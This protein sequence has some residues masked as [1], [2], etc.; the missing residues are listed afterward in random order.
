MIQ[1]H[2][3]STLIKPPIARKISKVDAI[4]GDIRTDDYFWLREK[5][6][7]DVIAYLDS[8]NA[9]TDAV[10]KPLENLQNKLYKETLDRIKQTDLSVPYKYG[11][12]WYY[13]RTEEGKQYQIY[14]R[15]LQ[16]MDG[17]EQVTLDLN[18]LSEGHKFL[19]L[20]VYKVSDDGNLLAYS[21]DTTGFRDYRCYIKDLRTSENLPENFEH[22]SSAEWSAD[23]T[24]LFFVT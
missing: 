3:A 17:E 18:L 14:C 21:L 22:A 8:E 2:A 15:K 12:Y 4:H 10:M 16:T 11:D 20:G 5:T 13:T 24:M 6:N 1:P 23:N 9:Y 7:P 19:G